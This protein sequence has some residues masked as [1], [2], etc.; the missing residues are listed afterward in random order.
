MKEK[1]IISYLKRSFK[2]IKNTSVIASYEFQ[3]ERTDNMIVVGITNTTQVNVGLPD[4]KYELE[5]V[6]DCWISDD[7]SGEDFNRIVEETERVLLPYINGKNP[8][9]TA[10][11]GDIPIVGIL[12][13][14]NDFSITSES[15]RCVFRYS[16][17]SSFPIQ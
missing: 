2:T 8:N 5:I 6:V 11:F 3:D 17:F 12:Y 15:N 9:Y 7:N 4:Y 14:G 13:N 1:E 16:L 10:L